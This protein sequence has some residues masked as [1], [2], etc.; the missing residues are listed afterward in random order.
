M[1]A[2]PYNGNAD[3]PDI[4][5]DLQLDQHRLSPSDHPDLHIIIYTPVPSTDASARLK[6]MLG[7]PRT[8]SA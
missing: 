2:P 8:A 3:L 4:A 1:A 7:G 5:G 6:L